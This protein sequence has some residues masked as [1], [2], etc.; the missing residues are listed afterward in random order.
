MISSVHNFILVIFF[1]YNEAWGADK[2]WAGMVL[3][4]L[5]DVV[6]IISYAQNRQFF[7]D[8]TLGKSVFTFT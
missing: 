1:R 6:A 4:L 3:L 7:D 2:I 8:D 5:C